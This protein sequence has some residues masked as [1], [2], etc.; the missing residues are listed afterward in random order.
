MSNERFAATNAVVANSAL[1][2]PAQEKPVISPGSRVLL[3]AW[4]LQGTIP[5]SE[6]E[7]QR[8]TACRGSLRT[9]FFC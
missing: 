3:R 9:H 7:Q 6:C 8:Q 2:T 1:T 4:Y 5:K